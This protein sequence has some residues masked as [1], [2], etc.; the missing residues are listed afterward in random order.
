MNCFVESGRSYFLNIQKEKLKPREDN[1]LKEHTG[2]TSVTLSQPF[3]LEICFPSS[4]LGPN[5]FH[6]VIYVASYKQ[7]NKEGYMSHYLQSQ[8]AVQN[9]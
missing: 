3:P 5:A 2:N 4:T 7:T 8:I 1:L 9:L 6:S